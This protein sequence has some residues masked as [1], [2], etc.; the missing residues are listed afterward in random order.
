TAGT[1]YCESIFALD[2][3]ATAQALAGFGRRADREELRWQFALQS[4]T[5]LAQACTSDL[6]EC[7]DV[8]EAMRDGYLLEFGLKVHDLD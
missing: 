8:M 5:S 1:G 3:L 6:A 2:S 4:M 7:V